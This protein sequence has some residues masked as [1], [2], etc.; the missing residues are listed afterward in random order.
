[1]NLDEFDY[2]LIRTMMIAALI[3]VFFTIIVIVYMGYSEFRLC[4]KW[5]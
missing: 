5:C 4:Q 1:M 2:W 3:L